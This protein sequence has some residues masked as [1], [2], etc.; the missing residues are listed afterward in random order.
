MQSPFTIPPPPSIPPLLNPF[1]VNPVSG[2]GFSPF[3]GPLPFGG[4]DAPY[5]IGLALPQAAPASYGST[6]Q[7]TPTY[8]LKDQAGGLVSVGTATDLHGGTVVTAALTTAKG[9]IIPFQSAPPS[10]LSL[11]RAPS[12]PSGA[13][14]ALTDSAGKPVPYS[15]ATDQH[16]GAVLQIRLTDVTGK[17][18]ALY[19]Q[20]DSLG[21]PLDGA[22]ASSAAR[23]PAFSAS[24]A[25][26]P[27]ATPQLP[28]SIQPFA[29]P[30]VP[31]NGFLI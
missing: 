17:S 18:T 24:P 27:T 14:P 25:L 22:P 28:K 10:G 16:G 23:L 11:T 7:S 8:S 5:K 9:G 26:T 29:T 20:V 30:S 2:V 12:A 13:L 6:G 21:I 3:G 19:S 4:F 31:S 1:G 15:V